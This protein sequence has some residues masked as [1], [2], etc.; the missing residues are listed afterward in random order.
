[1][2]IGIYGQAIYV[3]PARQIVIV[4]TAAVAGSH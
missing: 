4:Q 2:A 1:M 3:N